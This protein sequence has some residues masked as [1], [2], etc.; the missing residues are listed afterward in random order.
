MHAQ[1]LLV[2]EKGVP[3]AAVRRCH[4]GRWFGSGEVEM[5]KVWW[6]LKIHMDEVFPLP[7]LEKKERSVE[8]WHCTLMGGSVLNAWHE[9]GGSE[10]DSSGCQRGFLPPPGE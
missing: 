8:A 3:W 7:R 6:M 4:T 10:T 2:T 5:L 9:S 1:R